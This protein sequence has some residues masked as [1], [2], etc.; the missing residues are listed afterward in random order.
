MQELVRK[1]QYYLKNWS[2]LEANNPKA[3]EV[4]HGPAILFTLGLYDY[5][6]TGRHGHTLKEIEGE[7]LRENGK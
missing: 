5:I 1:R 3:F 7:V 2:R 6:A 4:M